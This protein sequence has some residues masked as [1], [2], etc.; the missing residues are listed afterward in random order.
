VF[1]VKHRPAATTS[2]VRARLRL[3]ADLLL[4]WNRPVNLIARADESSLWE[5]HI[6]DSLQLKRLIPVGIDRAVDLGSG[7]GFPGL[8]LAIST[9]VSW[10]LIEPDQRK[11]SFLREA[12]RITAAPVRV[13][14]VRAERASLDSTQL[15]TAR[16]LA[17][18]SKL[19]ALS[20]PFLTPDG[21]CIFPK[22]REA[23]NELT[24][25]RLRWHMQAQE[26]SSR[27]ASSSTIFFLSE[28]SPVGPSS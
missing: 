5:R 11:A 19:L 2:H 1:H 4:R 14:V 10:E 26:L 9:G 22:G 15:V 12:A 24:S 20:Y 3:F 28:I 18:L 7:G 27:T 8:V 17:P 6:N 16:G 13:H 23:A 25:A 21:V